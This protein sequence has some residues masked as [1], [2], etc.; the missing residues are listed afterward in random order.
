M[1]LRQP[2]SRVNLFL[3]GRK[4]KKA[5]C[6]RFV[7]DVSGILPAR[8]APL[9]QH[10]AAGKGEVARGLALCSP[11]RPCPR[12]HTQP[13]EMGLA[14]DQVLQLLTAHLDRVFKRERKKKG[15]KKTGL[16]SSR[17]AK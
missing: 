16:D 9:A 4:K 10:G 13:P 2:N 3:L 7:E 15:G 14:A 5:F 17:V 6:L 12:K 11:P 1:S 8:G